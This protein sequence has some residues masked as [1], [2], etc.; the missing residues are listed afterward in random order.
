MTFSASASR[1]PLAFDDRLEG[2]SLGFGVELQGI[3]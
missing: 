3:L 2:F 1:P